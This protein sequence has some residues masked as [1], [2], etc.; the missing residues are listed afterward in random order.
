M[1]TSRMIGEKTATM[2]QPSP[3]RTFSLDKAE[4]MLGMDKTLQD[5]RRDV[6]YLITA[7][8]TY[9]RQYGGLTW[10]V[11]KLSEVDGPTLEELRVAVTNLATFSNALVASLE[12]F[13]ASR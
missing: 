1:A 6:Q 11:Q 3:L 7:T 4:D 12:D 10:T 9:V 8:N 13:N 5:V 2:T